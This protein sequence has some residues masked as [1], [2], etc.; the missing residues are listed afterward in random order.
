MNYSAINLAEFENKRMDAEF[1]QK[2]YLHAKRT[3]SG[4]AL[5]S[6]FVKVFHPV[7]IKR[8]YSDNGSIRIVLAQ[9]VRDNL[10]DWGPSR[11]MDATHS[12]KL[13]PNKLKEGD[14]LVTRSGA[15]Y[16]QTSVITYEPK[17]EAIYA[18]ADLLLLN[19]GQI[20][21]P[22]LSTFLNTRIGKL[23]MLR[24]AYGAA[25]PHIAPSYINTIPFP[26]YLLKIKDRIQY[27]IYKSRGQ[28]KLSQNLYSQATQLLEQELAL[29]KLQ[30]KSQK[31]YTANFSEVV[32]N[33]RADAEFHN[34]YL[35]QLYQSIVRKTSKE[36]IPLNKLAKVLK[37]SNPDY[38][39]SEVPIITQKHL[40]EISPENFSLDLSASL[41][42][43]NKNQEAILRPRDLLFYSVGAYLGKTNMWLNEEKA[44]PAS[45]ITLIRPHSETDNAYLF[46]LLNS[47]Y[48]I[49]QSK[50]FQS[51]TSQQYIYPKDIKRFLIPQLG[52][53]L[54][55]KL[56]E[57]V[58]ESKKARK[59]SKQLLQQAI[60]EVE[61][62]I[63][64]EA[65]KNNQ[66]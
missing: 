52:T 50:T 61:T 3:I 38:A 60:I 2:K 8:I 43:L 11:Y 58:I 64:Q 31:S 10:M 48:G 33:N 46:L 35:R 26:D 40:S 63:E 66:S 24:G 65:I 25:Q 56:T 27:L 55:V 49:F 21:G 34:K 62:L 37:F 18:C 39:K 29:D 13:A 20:G 53:K 6:H 15:N 22:L 45:F 16:G 19:P 36:L 30:F 14:V 12:L 7:E 54:K 59:E 4:R 28:D 9:N 42:W 5:S 1:Y 51:G 32:N 17:E 47:S 41:S 57:L 23:L 44:V